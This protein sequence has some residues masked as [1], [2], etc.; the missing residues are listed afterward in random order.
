MPHYRQLLAAALATAVV[1][2]PSATAADELDVARDD[3]AAAQQRLEA[4]DDDLLTLS[5]RLRQLDLE[6]AAAAAELEATEAELATARDDLDQARIAQQAAA[7][8]ALVA[9]EAHERAIG[10]RDEA[11]GHLADRLMATYKHGPTSRHGTLLRAMTGSRSL[12][13]AA[14]ARESMNR[15]LLD[16]RDLLDRADAAATQALATATEA[17]HASRAAAD[18]TAAARGHADSI[19]ALER[20]QRALVSTLEADRR[21]QQQLSAQLES[22]HEDAA[23]LIDELTS[24][25][26]ELEAAQLTWH[27]PVTAMDSPPLTSDS[28]WADRLPAAGQRWAGHIEQAANGAGIDPRLLAAL[29]W[30][31]SGFRPDVTSHAGAIGLAQLMPA[32]ARGLGA[33]PYDPIQNLAAGARYLRQQLDHFGTVEL[34][35]AAYNAG[36]GAVTRH[37]GIPPFRETQLYVVTVTTRYQQLAS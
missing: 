15:V 9:R 16:D 1:L 7:A 20:H 14:A 31:E 6:L 3:H 22:D 28:P 12:H 29:V 36:P 37:A 19:A 35:L 25:I 2:A 27:P 21:E 17:E 23:T 10:E 13:D 24:R 26:A 4:L 18:T 11:D 33:N 34:A 32:T 5:D 30:S 8:A